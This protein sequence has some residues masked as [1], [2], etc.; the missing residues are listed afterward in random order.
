MKPGAVETVRNVIRAQAPYWGC[1]RLYER[2]IP[3]DLAVFAAS[4]R[5]SKV[6]DQEGEEEEEE[7]G[8]G[9]ELLSRSFRKMEVES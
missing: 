8:Q 3:E 5:E 2:K 9:V 6:Q 1:L 7:G 4:M